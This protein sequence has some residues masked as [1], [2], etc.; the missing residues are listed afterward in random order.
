MWERA[1]GVRPPRCAPRKQ[2]LTKTLKLGASWTSTLRSRAGQPQQRERAWSWCVSG[3][4][5]PRAA[6]VAV[7]GEDG[8]VAL[9]GSTA[10]GR[11]AAGVSVGKRVGGKARIVIRGRSAYDVRSG[12]VRAVGVATK[13]LAKHPAAL[14]AAV[15]EVSA[16]RAQQA[17]PAF[18]AGTNATTAPT[19]R[20]LAGT[21]N[22]VDDAALTLLCSLLSA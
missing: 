17:K 4:G 1:D 22:P 10:H 21:G 9:A 13:A 3:S 8:R 18:V 20:T 15:R 14:K 6:D 16:A 19:G 5:N 7:F 12:R 11:N 2:A